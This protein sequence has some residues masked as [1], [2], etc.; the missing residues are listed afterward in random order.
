MSIP[1]T[2]G[3]DTA[4]ILEA[5]GIAEP[6]LSDFGVAAE[7]FDADEHFHGAVSEDPTPGLAG[8]LIG[9]VEISD[10]PDPAAALA[11][12]GGLTLRWTPLPR[13][14]SR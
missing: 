13:D 5:V 9:G 4:G 12:V 2:P 8:L 6:E 1:Q 10:L 3:R 7:P 14:P 11:A